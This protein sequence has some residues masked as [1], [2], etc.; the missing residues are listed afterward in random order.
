MHSRPLSASGLGVANDTC[1]QYDI[2]IARA[3]YLYCV[4]NIGQVQH[5]IKRDDFTVELM[6]CCVDIFNR[7]VIAEQCL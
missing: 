3:R 1:N 5:G 6:D 7:G 2:G 4:F